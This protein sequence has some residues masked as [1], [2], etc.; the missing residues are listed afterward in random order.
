MSQTKTSKAN[1]L[2]IEDEDLIRT[3]SIQMLNRLGYSVH[4]APD[5]FEAIAYYEKNWANIDIIIL[6]LIMPLLS[7][8]ETYQ[9]LKEINPNLNVIIASGYNI[10]SEEIAYLVKSES[11]HFIQKPYN[12]KSLNEKI[13]EALERV[14]TQ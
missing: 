4:G 9:K 1:I 14:T 13:E 11:V 3:L 5:G 7:G 10:E 6:D 8:E 2:V 12:M